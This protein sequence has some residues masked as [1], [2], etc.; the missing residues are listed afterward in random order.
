MVRIIKKH[1]EKENQNNCKILLLRTAALGDFLFAVPA[2]ALIREKLPNAHIT[3]LTS[4]STNSYSRRSAMKYIATSNKLPWLKFVVPSL[5][6]AAIIIESLSIKHF[7]N[8]RKEIKKIKPDITIILPHPNDQLLGI[9]KKITFL[10]LIGVNKKIYGSNLVGLFLKFLKI[11]KEVDTV[12]KIMG[13]IQAISKVPYLMDIDKSKIY[14]PL[15][16]DQL[17][18]LWAKDFINKHNFFDKKFIAIAPGSIQPHKKWP[19]EKYLELIK[20]LINNFDIYIIVIGTSNDREV[21]EY[22]YENIDEIY[23]NRIILIAGE[24]SIQQSAAL[25]KKC[26]LIVGN[27]G[28]SMHLGAAV[29]IP[30]VSIIPGIEPVGSVD[31]WGNERFSVRHT[32]LDCS[33]CYSFTHCPEGHKKCM[34]DIPVQNVLQSLRLVI[35]SFDNKMARE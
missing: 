8:L 5:L 12:H 15:K 34:R 13:P 23:K 11:N 6:N 21:G 24:I 3:L 32:G 28:G 2:F 19:K 26:S 17:D 1:F 25:L 10:K 9:I 31:P 16:H 27:D 29:G 22:I 4:I 33:P 35:D 7:L 20:K 18:I 30:V 14:F